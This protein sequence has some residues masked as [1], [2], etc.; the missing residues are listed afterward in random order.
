MGANSAVL[1]GWHFPLTSWIRA[2]LFVAWIVLNGEI[3]T[4]NQTKGDVMRNMRIKLF[5]TAGIVALVFLLTIGQA[6]AWD[7]A[8][9]DQL[10]QLRHCPGCDLSGADLSGKN[11]SGHNLWRANLSYANLSGANLSNASFV[12]ANLSGSNL[13]GATLDGANFSGATS[14]FDDDFTCASP[15]IGGCYSECSPGGACH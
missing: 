2:V 8:H 7:Q 15:S 12:E 4:P 11:L 13:N 10:I 3:S 6:G 9:L 14:W 5:G 1:S